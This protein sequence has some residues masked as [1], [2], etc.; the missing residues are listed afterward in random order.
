MFG[1]NNSK[2]GDELIKCSE[3]C[4]RMVRRS[5]MADH[6][7]FAS[8]DHAVGRVARMANSEAYTI[9]ATACEQEQ[10]ALASKRQ[11]EQD[12]RQQE[13]EQRD[14]WMMLGARHAMA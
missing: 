11:Q 5:R 14:E 2:R 8:V 12:E 7:L 6:S 4:G 13:Q 3:G 10:R 1:I 9:I